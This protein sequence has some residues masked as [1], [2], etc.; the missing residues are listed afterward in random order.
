MYQIQEESSIL[1]TVPPLGF[2][3]GGVWRSFD[4]QSNTNRNGTMNFVRSY[5]VGVFASTVVAN[6]TN[7]TLG[8]TKAVS[9]GTFAHNNVK[10]ITARVTNEIAGVANTA[11]LRGDNKIDSSIHKT[12]E[13]RTAQTSTSFR[14]GCFNLFTG[15]FNYYV[16]PYTRVIAQTDSFGSDDASSPTNGVRGRVT[17]QTGRSKSV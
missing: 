9:A 14:D 8:N 2:A 12:E 16:P 3:V 1:M 5:D 4:S 6:S 17:Y 10:P 11:L 15:K 13:V 7:S